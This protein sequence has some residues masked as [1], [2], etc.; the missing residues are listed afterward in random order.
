[1]E[2]LTKAQK[3]AQAGI[4][5]LLNEIIIGIKIDR[6]LYPVERIQ[7]VLQKIY[8]TIKEYKLNDNFLNDYVEEVYRALYNA[9]RYLDA[10]TIAKKY[11]L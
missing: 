2:R 11:D 3:A 10:A 5:H 7:D 9:R 6:S 8:E 4:G 1:M